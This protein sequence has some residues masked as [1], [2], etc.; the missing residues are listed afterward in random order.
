LPQTFFRNAESYRWLLLLLIHIFGMPRDSALAYVLF[1]RTFVHD[2]VA[3]RF[4][5]RL[6]AYA[7]A[8]F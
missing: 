4:Y 1:I 2:Q 7:E 5:S 6:G 3:M 8:T